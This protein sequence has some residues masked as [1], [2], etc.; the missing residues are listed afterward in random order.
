MIERL[1]AELIG[2]LAIEKREHRREE[3]TGLIP[4]SGDSPRQS[5]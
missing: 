5:R 1:C 3:K 4:A 2:S